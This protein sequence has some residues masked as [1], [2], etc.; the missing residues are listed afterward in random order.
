[1]TG[2]KMRPFT[3]TIPVDEARAI[4]DRT[5]TPI[6]RTTRLS[7]SAAL[8]RVL[9]EDITADRDV[10]PFSRAGMDGYAVRAE[11]TT[12]ASKSTARLLNCVGQVFTGD[13]PTRSIG[14]G[15]CLEI[16]TG[17]PMPKGADAVVMV[18]DT[19]RDGQPVQI[20]SSVA[21]GQNVGRQGADIRVGQTILVDGARST[22]AVLEPSPR[23]ASARSPCTTCLVSRFCRPVTRSWSP[24]TV[25]RLARST[26]STASRFRPSSQTMGG[27]PCPGALRAT[28]SKTS[29]AQ[30]TNRGATTSSCFQV[31]AL[32][33]NAISSSTCSRSAARRSSTGWPSSPGK[34]TA[35]GRVGST[36]F[37][38]LPGYPTSCLSNAYI[39]V[40]AGAPQDGAPRARADRTIPCR[41]ARRW[42]RPS[43][44]HQFFTVRIANGMAMPAFKSSGDIT[45][46]SQAD[47][48][49]EIPVHVDIVEAG[50][51]VEVTLFL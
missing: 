12:G 22:R 8:G 29:T 32:S 39:L 5:I 25:S 51:P 20:F 43:G 6:A 42:Y 16:A 37:F 41:S 48:Y 14:P 23:W 21:P 9:A 36:P 44:R 10:P 27:T 49:I 4:I 11:D 3:R 1:M 34:P 15:E 38:G 35:F 45:S 30:S 26:T 17:A 24:A 33:A 28:P 7:L 50:T 31:E 40:A 46:M 18:E 19:F 47:G 2:T 13:A